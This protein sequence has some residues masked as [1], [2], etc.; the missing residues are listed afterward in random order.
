M[1][2]AMFKI[3]D[4]LHATEPVEFTKGSRDQ[5][6]LM[7]T[8]SPSGQCEHTQFPLLINFL[9][10]GDLLV[11]NNSRTIPALMI[12]N[13]GENRAEVRLSHRVN[14]SQ[15]RALVLTEEIEL[16]DTIIFSKNLLAVVSEGCE[17]TPLYTLSFSQSGSSLVDVFYQI[18]KPIHYEYIKKDIPLDAYQTVYGTVPGSVELASAGRPFTWAMLQQ[19]KDAGINIAFLQL[20]TGLSYFE[21]NLW[22]NP[23]QQPELFHVPERTARLVHETKKRGGRI[24]AVG[25]TVVRALE[26]AGKNRT[27]K[28]LNGSTNLYIHQAYNLK[29]IDG[30]LTGFHEPE[31]S[32][33]DMLSAFLHPDILKSTYEEAL[34][35]QYLWHEFGDIN[36]I[37]AGCL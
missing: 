19:L 13:I 8:D 32:H 35:K 4:H 5:V 28:A 33:L 9:K 10:K 3:P 17:N 36:L 20:H 11:F 31:A 25:T 18:G 30:L 16:G 15:W 26:S 21:N 24:I 1:N 14:D 27:I 34:S 23:V 22:P 37:L 2:E 6:S 29:V 7:V 12:G